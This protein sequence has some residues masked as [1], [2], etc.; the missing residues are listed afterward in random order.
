KETKTI[1]YMS[2]I[3]TQTEDF[4]TIENIEEPVIINY[5]VTIN[6][7][8]F[9]ETAALFAEEGELLAPFEK[10]IL[11]KEA[12]A[13]YLSKEAK[14]MKLL[15]QQGIYELNE[16]DLETIKVTGKVKTP[17]FSVNVAWHFCL[18][19]DQQITTIKIKLLASPQEL[20]GLQ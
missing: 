17:L 13:S 7:G 20:L 5:F 11:G 18:N 8:K 10:P 19:S 16:D 4:I 12:I 15:P 1:S 9:I 6:H 2:S 14:G 3:E